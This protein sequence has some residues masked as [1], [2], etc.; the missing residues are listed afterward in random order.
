MKLKLIY[1]VQYERLLP[2]KVKAIALLECSACKPYDDNCPGF[3]C[4]IDCLCF[5]LSP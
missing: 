2:V 4:L 3:T 5:K 1:G